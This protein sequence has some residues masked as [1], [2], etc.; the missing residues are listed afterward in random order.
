MS[1]PEAKTNIYVSTSL[2]ANLLYNMDQRVLNS[3]VLVGCPEKTVPLI[4][5]ANP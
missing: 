3:V 2:K 5:K 1:S 4:V